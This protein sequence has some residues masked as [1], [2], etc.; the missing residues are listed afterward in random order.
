MGPKS[1][2]SKERQRAILDS[3]NMIEVLLRKDG[4]EAETRR[5]AERI[6]ERLM[7]YEAFTHLSR[8]RAVH[9]VGDTEHADFAI[10]L[11]EGEEV[12]PVIMVEL[13]RVGVDLAVKHVKQ[14]SRYAIDAGCEWVLLTNARQWRLYH[15]EFGQPPDIR[16]VEHWDLIHDELDVLD[17]KFSLLS[18][19]GLKRGSLDTLWKRTKVLA[20]D[21][22]LKAILSDDVV[23]VLRR[24][25]KRDA[26]VAVSADHIVGGLRKMLNDNAASILDDVQVSLPEPEEKGST[27][28][29][30]KGGA[31]CRLSD[32]IAAGL[33][34]PDTALFVD[35]KGTRHE[36][37]VRGDGTVEFEGQVHK[38]PSSAGGAV[39]AKHN[40][41]APNG[42]RFWKFLDSEGVAQPLETLRQAYQQTQT[43]SEIDATSEA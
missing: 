27:Q 39:T 23:T 36:A 38:T 9:G 34:H 43:E 37:H 17:Q 29:L 21:S 12:P 6:F 11:E 32:L 16:L 1:T 10:Q 20:P 33:I 22:L 28:R 25:L 7:G 14:A 19:R 13:K 35:Y 18:L 3:R 24:V 5:R 41:H 42:W 40:I 8:E 15:V 4:N 26:R 30:G 2:L 31:R